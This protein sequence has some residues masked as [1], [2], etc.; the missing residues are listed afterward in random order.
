MDEQYKEATKQASF[1]AM[2]PFLNELRNDNSRWEK[3]EKAF[4]KHRKIVFCANQLVQPCSLTK[5]A[6]LTTD[7]S[8]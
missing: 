8:K 5:G 6:S 2:N 1:A 3:D 4:E 7:A